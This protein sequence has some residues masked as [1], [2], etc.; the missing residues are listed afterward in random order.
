MAS[1]VAAKYTVEKLKS[2]YKSLKDAKAALNIKARGWTA[3]VEK[4]NAPNYEQL[5]EQVAQLIQ[6]N[7]DLRK[8]NEILR[9]SVSRTE[10]F[11]EVGFWLAD[12]NF[13]RS[14]FPDFNVPPEATKIESAAKAFYK[15][16][17]QKY[18]PDKGGT[19]MQMS[20]LGRL[21]DQLMALVEMNGGLR[22]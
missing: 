7:E 12:N 9:Q 16:L 17:A 18:H 15:T 11:D 6:E 21:F 3:L 5:K 2:Q 20:N 14:R 22:K 8:E 1:S 13:D 10:N 4:L 19:E